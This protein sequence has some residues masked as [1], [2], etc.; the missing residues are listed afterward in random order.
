MVIQAAG[1]EVKRPQETAPPVGAPQRPTVTIGFL[2]R[3]LG[4]SCALRFELEG[5]SSFQIAM[6]FFGR[7]RLAGG[8]AAER[9][10]GNR[11]QELTMRWPTF[12]PGAK[13]S[14]QGTNN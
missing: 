10:R 3:R 12:A 8:A 6:R 13:R 11:C 5:N 2:P 1:T 9:F 4:E 14:H 7:A